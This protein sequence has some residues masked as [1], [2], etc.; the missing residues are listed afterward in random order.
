[1]N[2]KKHWVDQR[3]DTAEFLSLLFWLV[4]FPFSLLPPPLHGEPKQTPLYQMIL[5]QITPSRKSPHKTPGHSSGHKTPTDPAMPRYGS[6]FLLGDT[7]G[8]ARSRTM[9]CTPRRCLNPASPPTALGGC[10]QPELQT[11]QNIRR[12]KDNVHITGNCREHLS[13]YS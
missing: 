1:M 10:A 8:V 5:S 11:D 4:K 12:R 2:T 3:E 9:A 7:A 6:G 13:G